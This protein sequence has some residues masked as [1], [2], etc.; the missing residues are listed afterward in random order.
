[1]QPAT[2]SWGSARSPQQSL[3][4][5]PDRDSR[6]S[7]QHFNQ[8]LQN[9]DVPPQARGIGAPRHDMGRSPHRG[10]EAR[11]TLWPAWEEGRALA[12]TVRNGGNTGRS[13]R[14]QEQCELRPRGERKGSLWK[15]PRRARGGISTGA[16]CLG[17]GGSGLQL[18]ALR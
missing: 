11:L 16:G 3:P 17:F 10:R 14:A 18:S 2:L 7:G 5:S 9:R 6:R 1:M 15:E 4:F 12:E 13:V 8:S